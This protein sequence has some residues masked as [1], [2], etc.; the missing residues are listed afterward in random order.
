MKRIGKLLWVYIQ[1]NIEPDCGSLPPNR[2]TLLLVLCH[3]R[4]NQDINTIKNT[5]FNFTLHSNFNFPPR[6]P[7]PPSHLSIFMFVDVMP[8][9]LCTICLQC[10]LWP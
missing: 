8:A 1:D 4:R 9:S 2:D 7:V 3:G 5:Y 6:L 10:P